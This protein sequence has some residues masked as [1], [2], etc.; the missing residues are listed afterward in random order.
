V[1]I[2]TRDGF[3]VELRNV[4]NVYLGGKEAEQI[5]RVN[6]KPA[7]GLLVYKQ[8]AANITRTV[9]SVLP[10]VEQVNQE[11]PAG[12][13]LQ[14]VIDQS[15]SVRETV[16]EVQHEL[17]LAAILTGVVLFFFI[18]SVRS[19][20]IVLLAIPASLLVSLIVLKLTGL[21]LNGMTLIGLTT[22]IGVLVDDSIVVLENI[23]SHL[24]RGKE[25]KSAAIDG[26][27]EIGM[28]AIAIT[29]VDVAV[30]GPI[31][32]ISGI[33]GAFLRN[34]AI[35][36]VAAT[37]ASLLVSFTL[38]PL[39]A[40]RWLSNRG[41]SRSPLARIARVWE[42]LY[43]ALERFY[44]R[45]LRWSL[46]HRLLVVL[47]AILVLLSNAFIMRFLGSEF[48]PEADRDVVTVVGEMPAGTALEATDRAAR[49][50]ERA[51]LDESSFPD[52]HT[53]YVEV[54][55]DGDSRKVRV[56]LE[57]GT[58]SNREL[59]SKDIG[60]AAV[61][62]GVAAVPELH[63]YQF[64][65]NGGL[66]QPVQVRIFNDDLDALTVQ[67]KQA[68]TWLASLPELTD[69]TNSLTAAT[70]ITVS[71]DLARLRDM[72]MSSRQIATAVRVAY[73][74]AE[75]GRWTDSLGKERDVRVK[76]PADLR[77]RPEAI[78]DL[79]VGRRG[80]MP[81]ALRQVATETSEV[82]PTRITRVN[83]QRVAT[84][85]A[86]AN[87]VPLGAAT[88][89]ASAVMNELGVGRWSL[90][91]TGDEQQSSFA[92]LGTGLA[93]SILLM[94]F[95]LAMLY[96]SWLQPMLILSALPLA[97]VGGFLGLLIFHQTLSVP[98]F[99]GLIALFG[100]VGKNSILLVDRANDLRKHGLDRMA[101]L[102]EAGPSRLRPILMTSAVLILSTLPVAMR[103][104]DG[105]AAR[106]P[107][108]AVLV[109]GMATSTVLSLLYVP[110]AYT[111]FDSLGVWLGRLFNFRPFRKR[112]Q[113]TAMALASAPAPSTPAAPRTLRVI[114][115]AEVE[116]V[117][118]NRP[119]RHFEPSNRRRAYPAS[120]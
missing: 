100:L 101:A 48:V 78:A 72:G 11:M 74:G 93:L 87:D 14:L 29:L 84:I 117:P 49:Q 89:A 23:F 65:G 82:R 104:G 24:E 52:V 27:S 71:P 20:I 15:T 99:I 86:E 7:V 69:V 12:F 38:T 61:E 92:A 57:V 114:T 28:A 33:T 53:T 62:A 21:T 120:A 39:I 90:A 105:G 13:N 64:T 81:V 22:A 63:A 103:L 106:A 10:A 17:L 75:V 70:E 50:W 107:L 43:Q 5:L 58:P 83:R 55:A 32:G 113:N 47:A 31:I 1:P 3:S 77:N 34:F 76:V 56:N 115:A 54:G 109:G 112:Q 67:A 118:R 68:E 108:G 60:R 110:V 6:G 79:P 96:E 98:S 97:S 102:Q 66:G 2:I 116:D 119:R 16:S 91:G 73:Q 18:H 88:T 30:W 41:E 9:D 35:V 80:D 8:S 46:H 25:P 95:V 59:T 19:T 36:I 51:L 44:T 37:L 42:P 26:R 45:A 111:Y 40:S 4:A 94:Y 85:G